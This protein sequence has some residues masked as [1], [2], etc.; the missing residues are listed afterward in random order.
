MEK[1][2]AFPNDTKPTLKRYGLF[3]GEQPRINN[4]NKPSVK[5]D[6]KYWRSFEMEPQKQGVIPENNSIE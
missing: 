6:E 3:L 2:K 5:K 4:L 1:L